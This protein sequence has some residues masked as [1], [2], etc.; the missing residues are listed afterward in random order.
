VTD[1]DRWLLPEGI[2]EI[3][4]PEARHLEELRRRLIDLFASWGYEQVMPPLIE[5]LEALLTGTGRELDLQTFKLTDQLSGRLM[6]VRAD[7]TPQVARIDAHYLKRETPVRLCYAGPVL[8]T[9]P[10][11]FA[12]SRELLQIGAEL[13]GHDGPGSDVEIIGLMLEMLRSAGVRQE[14]L[15]L[16]HVGIFRELARDAGISLDQE[17]ALSDAIRRK[18]APEVDELLAGW[19]IPSRQARPLA[20][21]LEL[22]GG[23]EVLDRA[24]MAYSKSSPGVQAALANL[25]TIA[26]QLRHHHTGI[27]LHFDLAE[28]TGYRYYTG[29]VFATFVAGQGKALA[30]GG[31]YNGIGRAFGRERAATGFS[32]DLRFVATLAPAGRAGFRTVLAPMSEDAALAAEIKRLRGAGDRVIMGL[33]GVTATASDLG[34]SHELVRQGER[35]VLRSV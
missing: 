20:T 10:D 15:D 32:A 7:F 18:S 21:L 29:A 3:L 1:L 17:R 19:G 4:P 13:Y 12:G 8:H 5:Y 23:S 26:Q 22:S 30:R 27:A 9:R 2:E 33:P 11:E 34:C 6:G 35:W 31:R 16:G 14:C 28:L 25:E 24:R